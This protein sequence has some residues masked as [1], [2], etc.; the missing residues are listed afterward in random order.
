[1]HPSLEQF[2]QSLA[3]AGLLT[4]NDVQSAVESWVGNNQPTDSASFAEL[5]VSSGKLTPFQAQEL[6]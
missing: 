5:L 2:V 6:L 1:M 4:E 3:A